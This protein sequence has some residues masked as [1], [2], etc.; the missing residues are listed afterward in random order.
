MC[1]YL[2]RPIWFALFLFMLPISTSQLQSQ[3]SRKFNTSQVQIDSLKALVLI[4]SDEEIPSLYNQLII[5]Y[6]GVSYDSVRVYVGKAIAAS[7]ALE[8]IANLARAIRFRG[9]LSSGEN[10]YQEAIESNFEAIALASKIN[11]YDL[12]AL[13]YNNIG[14]ICHTTF[15]LESG[16]ENLF[17]GLRISEEHDL[18]DKSI[19]GLLLGNIASCYTLMED[20]EMAL[21]YLRRVMS[22]AK[23]I[24]NDNLRLRFCDEISI[25]MLENN[26]EAEAYTTA[27]KCLEETKESGFTEAAMN[28]SLAMSKILFKQADYPSAIKMIEDSEEMANE[29]GYK[30]LIPDLLLFESKIHAKQSNI[31]QAISLAEEALEG[32]NFLRSKQA[33]DIT[34]HL[35]D[36]F[37][38][39]KDYKNAMFYQSQHLKWTAA[40]Q[41]QKVIYKAA[42][43]ESKYKNKNQQKQIEFLNREKL[44]K[45]KT[46]VL[47]L[48]A[49]GV[50]SFA[51]IIGFILYRENQK[52]TL[53]L[54]VVNS[55]LKDTQHELKNKHDDLERYIE[56]NIQLEQFAH[57][58]SHDL[59]APIITIKSF[60][61]LLT[62][63][64]STKLNEKEKQ[65]LN[66]VS[67][68]ADQM[69][70]LVT[71]LL[72][73]S[74][75]NSQDLNLE[76]INIG[77]LV[78]DVTNM[79]DQTLGGRDIQIRILGKFPRL[80]VDKVK[81]KRV[82]QNLIS[83]AVK[84]SDPT[85]KNEI[86]ISSQEH[87][88]HHL[89][90]VSDTGVG[91]DSGINKIDIFQPFTQLNPKKEYSGTG[92]GLG[93]C[94]KI[95]KK[96]GGE[97]GYSSTLGEGSEF[98]FKIYKS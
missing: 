93:I 37:E 73:Y 33:A 84:F 98:Y 25:S 54:K 81:L 32:E 75:I 46:N 83:N 43:L 68:N 27:T 58:A 18:E 36:L 82:F 3:N 65:Y 72:E 59:R 53:A 52:R 5:K 69:D 80:I 24:N 78:R 34:K 17:E 9:V 91:I 11:D 97:I 31:P 79:F 41:E 12:Q 6:A 14:Y 64:A 42:E 10:K 86:A 66:Y 28:A 74:K 63:R 22:Y 71:D 35:S 85:R 44:L 20:H 89:F 15:Q 57:V 29:I 96:H 92:I 88:D 94:Q 4:S 38:K 23:S 8:D 70:S 26:F 76:S 7:E 49:L 87:Q 40:D 77:D 62:K 45:E 21:K 61:D 51:L 90:K 1:H 50:L 60:A 67:D 19:R 30:H 95:I 55:E 48:K 39:E 47:Y 2:L 16:I 56:S 13:C